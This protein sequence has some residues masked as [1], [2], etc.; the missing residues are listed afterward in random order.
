[1]AD[2]AST[3]TWYST[4]TTTV[5]GNVVG[6]PVN[7]VGGIPSDRTVCHLYGNGSKTPNVGGTAGTQDFTGVPDS[8]PVGL[9]QRGI[10]DTWYG[11]TACQI[12]ANGMGFQLHKDSIVSGNTIPAKGDIYG[13]QTIRSWAGDVSRKP[14]GPAFG[15]DPKLQ[16]SANYA[17]QSRSASAGTVQY[18][19]LVLS[20]VDTTVPAQSPHASIW[21]TISL[22][23]SRGTHT[24][25]VHS[26]HSGQTPNYIIDTYLATGPAFLT[27]VPGSQTFPATI[28]TSTWYG[29][30]ISESQLTAAIVEVNRVMYIEDPTRTPYSL[31]PDVYAVNIVA[32]GTEMYSP[33]GTTGWIGSRLSGLSLQTIH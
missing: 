1:M 27:P 22:W 3:F 9:S 2:T 26:D 30:T 6:D 33:A 24:E 25:T 17:V 31:N 16:I 32:G 14:W 8:A 5:A 21:L 4:E 23:D 20:L 11:S 13:M 10:T 19:Q 29:A 7:G 28:P 12:T 18:G 15:A